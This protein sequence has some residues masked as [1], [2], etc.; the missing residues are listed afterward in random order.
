MISSAEAATGA[1]LKEPLHF[2]HYW[3]MSKTEHSS[4]WPGEDLL[5][6]SYSH[7]KLTLLQSSKR[8]TQHSRVKA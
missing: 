1:I 3:I 7:E 5:V 6:N 2:P 8:W 4:G